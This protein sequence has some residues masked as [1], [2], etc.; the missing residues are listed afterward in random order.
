MVSYRHANQRHHLRSDRHQIVQLSAEDQIEHLNAVAAD[1]GWTVDHGLQRPSHAGEEGSRAPSWRGCHARYDPAWRGPEGSPVVGG[2]YW[3]LSAR[4]GWVPGGMPGGWCFDVYLH[5]RKIDT[6]TANGMSLFDLA[7]M[8]AFHVRQSRRDRILRGQAAARNS[9]V[10]FG[11]PPIS[12]AKAEKA[13][14]LLANGTG[15]VR[16]VAK[17]A[18]ISAA[19]VSR[20][21]VT[22]EQASLSIA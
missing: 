18:G 21:K 20:L 9:N 19:S 3:T 1:H 15:S 12:I 2:S 7:S 10:K 4:V 5:D 22:M 8:M 13:K 11:R 17:L 16:R 6:A 14:Q